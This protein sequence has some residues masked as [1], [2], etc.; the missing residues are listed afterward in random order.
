MES[1]H[2]FSSRPDCNNTAEVPS[3]TLRTAL[4]AIPFVSDLWCRRTMIPGK[5]FTIFSKFHGIVSVNDFRF[6]IWLQELLQASLGALWSFC[7]AR[8]C[9]DP[10]SGQVLHHD[11]I[12][13]IVS[14]FTIFTENFV[15]CC[16]QVTKIFCTRYGFAIASSAWGPCNFGPLTD[17]AISVFREV[18]INTVLTQI[19]TSLECGLQRRFMRRTGVRVS[20]YWNFIIHQNFPEFLQPLWDLRIQRVAPFYRGFIRLPWSIINRSW[21]LHWRDVTFNLILSFSSLGITYCRWRRRAGR[22]CRTMTLPSW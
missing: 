13:V 20:M 12:S 8:I 7:F 4:S 14:R 5:I 6:P 11:C 3:F 17:L 10:L 18:S 15:I 19:L 9:L 1:A 2:Q 22:R 16:Y 21:H